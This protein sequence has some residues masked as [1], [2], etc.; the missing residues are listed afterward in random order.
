MA[1]KQKALSADL[2]VNNAET[3]VSYLDNPSAIAEIKSEWFKYISSP[4]DVKTPVEKVKKR[5]DGFDYVESSW[6][7]YQTKLFMPKYRYELLHVSF[8]HGW[9]NIIISLTDRI[10][11][12]IEL[13]ADSARIM[14]KRDAEQ[15]SFRDIIDMGNNLKSALSKA[16]KNAQ[17]RFGI[18]AD[19]YQKRESE[20]TSDERKRYDTML[21]RV[22]ELSP[23]RAQIFKDQWADLGTDW[24]DFLDKWQVYIDRSSK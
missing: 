22:K 4:K 23:T 20:P 13:G 11:G 18:S 1:T 12:N 7:D 5:P 2:E 16:I 10:T 21:V 9:I 17:S 15:P 24:S 8:E 3:T 14:V 6:M 19:V